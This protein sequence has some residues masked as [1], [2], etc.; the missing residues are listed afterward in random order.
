VVLGFIGA[1]LVGFLLIRAKAL[2]KASIELIL[3]NS[4]ADLILGSIILGLVVVYFI[5]KKF[6]KN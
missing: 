3:P 2:F 6:I 5:W 4:N 1:L